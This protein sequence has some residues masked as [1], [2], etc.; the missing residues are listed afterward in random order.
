[1][2]MAQAHRR[3]ND[4]EAQPASSRVRVRRLP[5]RGRYE[6]ESID[7]ILDEGFVCHVG[8]LGPEGPVVIPTAYGRDGDRLYLHGAPANAML[9]TASTGTQVCVS[10]TLI[11]GLVLARSA[12]HHS[13]NYRSV[14][15]YGI[16]EEV[17]DADEKRRAL[18]LIVEH[19]VPGRNADA[20]PPTPAEVRATRVVWVPLREA[21]AKVRTGGPIDDEEDLALPVWAGELPIVPAIGPPVAAEGVAADRRAPGYV[22]TYRRGGSIAP[23]AAPDGEAAALG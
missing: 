14:V 19:L 11:D 9:Q 1:M 3:R 8:F 10:V 2:V 13:I 6:R 22:T 16:G 7:A 5:E 20:R 4:G 21:S 23:G 12:F 15:I 17:T 18:A